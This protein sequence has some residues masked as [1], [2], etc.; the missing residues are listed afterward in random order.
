MARL[1]PQPPVRE[2]G[3][4]TTA[5]LFEEIKNRMEKKEPET[6]S[7]SKT[8]SSQSSTGTGSSARNVSFISPER[9]A[10][11]AA[12]STP[13][14]PSRQNSTA[15]ES[16]ARP[17]APTP[18]S[19]SASSLKADVLVSPASSKSRAAALVQ[20][21]LSSHF[22]APKPPSASAAPRASSGRPYSSCLLYGL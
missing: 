12:A 14:F 6:P 5:E 8:G 13:S 16:I 19:A 15:S 3:S 21:D 1:E 11:P 20:M 17:P 9:P 22:T 10:H 2:L 4:F 18:M 7:G